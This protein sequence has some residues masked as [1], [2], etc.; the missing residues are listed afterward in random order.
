MTLLL[1]ALAAGAIATSDSTSTAS[2]R[3]EYD[4][5][6]VVWEQHTIFNDVM[7]WAVQNGVIS[8]SQYGII[9]AEL[10]KRLEFVAEN[11][12]SDVLGTITC[13]CFLPIYDGSLL[14]IRS[15]RRQNRI[16]SW[17]PLSSHPPA[18]VRHS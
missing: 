13:L 10:T 14:A 12:G 1:L 5:Q 17:E 15:R 6:A 18:L 16:Y 4:L 8:S 9:Q 2:E 7:D 11:E 3:T